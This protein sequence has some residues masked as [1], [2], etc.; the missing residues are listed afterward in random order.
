VIHDS[1]LITKSD[2]MKT[3]MI[4]QTQRILNLIAKRDLDDDGRISLKMIQGPEFRSTFVCVLC[5]RKA[6]IDR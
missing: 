2:N 5:F 3:D 1:I 4:Q 6:A